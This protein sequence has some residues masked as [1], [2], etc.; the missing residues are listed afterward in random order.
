[1]PER[2][3]KVLARQGL[4]SR[5]EIEAWIRAG[6]LRVNGKPATL[7]VSVTEADSVELDGKPVAVSEQRPY[8]R[9]IAYHKPVGELTT[10]RDPEGRPTV[11][12]RLPALKAGRWVAIGRLDFNTSGLLLLT[13]DGELANRL[14]HPS[15]QV[16]R[17]Y[18]VRV[19]GEV[20]GLV[21]DNL[22][23]GVELE[24]GPA[25][26]ESIT[27]AGGRGA[28]QWYHVVLREGRNREV[29]RLWESQGLQVSRLIRVRYG[30]V[31]LPPGLREGRWENLPNPVIN[32]LLNLVGLHQQDYVPRAV[33]R[34]P[35]PGKAAS[36]KAASRKTPDKAAA[37]RR[38]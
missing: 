1:M 21:I 19:F 5:R 22:L 3:Q 13:D 17:E 18:A 20:D 29:R 36:R 24:E 23:G 32:T 11:F 34:P 31:A 38:R 7:G 33:Q 37:R 14:M 6:R 15:Q 8:P 12:D 10:R 27:E 35:S 25:R 26:F 4:G 9:V 30:P 28:N 2:L 16:E